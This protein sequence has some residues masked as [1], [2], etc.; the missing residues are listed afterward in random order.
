MKTLSALILT[1]GFLAA[2]QPQ[3]E[4]ARLETR[5][6]PGSLK[7]ELAQHGAGP[8]WAS[9]SE[10]MTPG[11]H[12]DMCWSNGNYEDGHATGAPVRVDADAGLPARTDVSGDRWRWRG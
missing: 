1:A 2:Q 7:S 10:P 9:W 12:G 3:V 6:F 8:F 11:R 4:N 5:A